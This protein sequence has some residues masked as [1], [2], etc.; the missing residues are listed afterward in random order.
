MDIHPTFLTHPLRYTRL[1]CNE[2]VALLRVNTLWTYAFS[3]PF[4]WLSGKTS[5]LADWSLYKMSET[6][7]LV[8][9]A[10]E[11]IVENPAR[12][13]DPNFDMFASVAEQMPEFKEWRQQLHEQTITSADGVRHFKNQEVLREARTPPVGSGNEQ[14]TPLTLE[15]AKV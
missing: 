5:K 8:E 4:R 11:E 15:L 12:I 10:M 6:L 2:F 3:A 9:K 13:L 1:R 14:A 7:D